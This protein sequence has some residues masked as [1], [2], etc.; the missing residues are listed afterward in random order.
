MPVAKAYLMSF[1]R[2]MMRGIP[3]PS[4]DGRSQKVPEAIL[5]I[6]GFYGNHT[7]MG[8][9]SIANRSKTFSIREFA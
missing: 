8:R 5:L 9:D 1:K 2:F 6:H 4:V 3:E 7:A